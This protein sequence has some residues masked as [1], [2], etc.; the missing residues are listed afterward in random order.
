M[1]RANARTSVHT[2]RAHSRVPILVTFRNALILR[3]NNLRSRKPDHRTEAMP[4]RHPVRR[5]PTES[6]SEL[7][8][9]IGVHVGR[10]WL[11]DDV[12]V[13]FVNWSVL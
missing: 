12:K 6:G 11:Y 3:C 8:I 9:A 4:A 5:T 10:G 2:W 7:P 1:V 13:G